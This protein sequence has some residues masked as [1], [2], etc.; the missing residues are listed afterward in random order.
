MYFTAAFPEIGTLKVVS[1]E[2]AYSTGL[3]CGWNRLAI[4][5]IFALYNYLF[6]ITTF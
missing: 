4:F 1:F 5:E 6:N 2:K 3:N